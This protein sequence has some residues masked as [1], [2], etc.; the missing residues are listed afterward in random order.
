M[1]WIARLWFYAVAIG[2]AIWTL[3]SVPA[4]PPSERHFALVASAIFFAVYIVPITVLAAVIEPEES[5]VLVE[6]YGK[7][8]ISYSEIRWCR[9]IFVFPFQ[10]VIVTTRRRFPLNLLIEGD[11]VSGRRR[12]LIQDGDK[13]ARIRALM[14]RAHVA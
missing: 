10:V 8:E 13:A 7:T 12:S 3:L 4:L 1:S 5:G 2:Y 6:Q 14:A 11:R 9:G